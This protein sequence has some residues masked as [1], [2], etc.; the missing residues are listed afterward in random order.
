MSNVLG[1][2]RGAQ[3]ALG[4]LGDSRGAQAAL[5]VTTD[6]D[7]LLRL[8]RRAER[9]T[10]RIELLEEELVTARGELDTLN[11]QREAVTERRA[12]LAKASP[13]DTGTGDRAK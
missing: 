9:V 5:G 2:S 1:D 10:A 4:V 7:H 8:A 6:D 13:P 12:A 3:A 11:A